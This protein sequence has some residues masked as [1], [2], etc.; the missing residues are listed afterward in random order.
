MSF[1]PTLSVTGSTGLTGPLDAV[2][3]RMM[4]STEEAALAAF[5][6]LALAQSHRLEVDPRSN[7]LNSEDEKTLGL[8]FTFDQ[9]RKALDT[10]DADAAELWPDRIPR[11]RAVQLMLVQVDEELDRLGGVFGAELTFSKDGYVT[12]QVRS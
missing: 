6:F 12:V 2:N 7:A 11:F 4:T 3:A 9:F 8:R 5:F 1:A 10:Y